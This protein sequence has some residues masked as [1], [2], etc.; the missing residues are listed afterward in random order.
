LGA[1]KKVLPLRAMVALDRLLQPLGRVAPLSPSIF[2]E[3]RV[4]GGAASPVAH[5]AMFICPL[6]GLP[7]RYERGGDDMNGVLAC[8]QGHR[9]GLREGIYDF[10]EPL[11]QS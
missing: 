1:F 9:W 7:L 10:K 3:N 8:E 4:R 11:E 2:V 6:D 5:E